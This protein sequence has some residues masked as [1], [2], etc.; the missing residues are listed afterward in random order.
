MPSA[1]GFFS[2]LLD[3]GLFEKIFSDAPDNI[4]EKLLGDDEPGDWER[5]S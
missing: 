5:A 1:A 4:E 2:S 3:V